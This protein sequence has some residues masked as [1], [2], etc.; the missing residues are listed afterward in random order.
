MTDTPA[1]VLDEL[2]TIACGECDWQMDVSH[3]TT[4]AAFQEAQD[5]QDVEHYEAPIKWEGVH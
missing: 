1:S 5:H 3:L 2:Q 4:K